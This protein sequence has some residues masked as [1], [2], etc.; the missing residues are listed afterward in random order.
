MHRPATEAI[1]CGPKITSRPGA[2]NH[3]Y[4]LP[5]PLQRF[6]DAAIFAVLGRE[7]EGTGARQARLSRQSA[8]GASGAS[9]AGARP[10]MRPP[11]PRAGP[12]GNPVHFLRLGSRLDAAGRHP[13]PPPPP[14][15]RE[16]LHHT[17]SRFAARFLSRPSGDA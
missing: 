12:D 3:A 17:V 1:S 16:S 14:S 13:P 9:S 7:E 6:L 15:H 10:S 4:R 5:R 11:E 8:A 2:R